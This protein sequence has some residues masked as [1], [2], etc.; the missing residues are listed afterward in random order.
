M[1]EGK[2]VEKMC[3]KRRYKQ[4]SSGGCRKLLKLHGT[5]KRGNEI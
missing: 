5:E 3:K 2:G 1:N 4:E